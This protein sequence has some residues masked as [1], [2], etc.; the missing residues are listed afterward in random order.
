VDLLKEMEKSGYVFIHD[1]GLDDPDGALQ[2][3]LSSFAE[4]ISYLD[5]PLVMDLK[6]QPGFQPA[7]YAGTGEFDLHTDLS[8]F[9]KPPTYIAMFCVSNEATGGGIPLL[10]DGWRAL[11]SL[12]EADVQYLKTE[13]VT[14]PPPSHIDYPPLSGPIV[15]EQDGK[16][17]IRF[18]YD[19]LDNP[20]APVRRFFETVQAQVMH[21]DVSPGT[22]YIFDNER[23]L[24]GRT[25]LKAGLGSNRFFK[26]MYGEVRG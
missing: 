12:T 4:P 26:R 22:I 1:I 18:R 19:M 15:V 11:E 2:E 6:P 23:M 7:S 16:L 10:A 9:E 8:W 17:V 24:H 5:L 21:L 3:Y 25:E 20:A 14:F 13:P